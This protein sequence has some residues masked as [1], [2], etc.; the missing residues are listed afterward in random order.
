[1]NR[2]ILAILAISGALFLGAKAQASNTMFPITVDVTITSLVPDPKLLVRLTNLSANPLTV[3]KSSLPWGNR[4]S[5]IVV[6]VRV[7]GVNEVLPTPPVIDDPGPDRL[8]I[9]AGETLS[10]EINLAHRFANFTSGA[11][12][13][14]DLL[15]FWSY[16]L[17][18]VDH[19]A[20]ERVGGWLQVR[21]E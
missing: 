8:V 14:G 12:G 1:M 18:T 20:S 5:M 13:K 19:Q 16:Q 6:A 2:S 17:T 11:G 10:G 3:Y 4:Y 21:R 7:A 9:G 15:L